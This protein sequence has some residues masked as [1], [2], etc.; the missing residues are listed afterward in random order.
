MLYSS[1]LLTY[2][3]TIKIVISEIQYAPNPIW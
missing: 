3:L 1:E 2:G